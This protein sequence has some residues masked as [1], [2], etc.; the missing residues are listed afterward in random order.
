M[1]YL[2]LYSVGNISPHDTS[3][4]H[5]TIQPAN[6]PNLKR[7]VFNVTLGAVMKN[8]DKVIKLRQ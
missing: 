5:S 2:L 6:K 7:K 8:M 3:V 1:R 4:S